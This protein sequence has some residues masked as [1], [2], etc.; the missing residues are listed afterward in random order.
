ME[1]QNK[2]AVLKINPPPKNCKE[3]IL[4]IMTTEISRN[5]EFG[6][7]D[8]FSCAGHKGRGTL[9]PEFD[10]L[11]NYNDYSIGTAPNCPL[12]IFRME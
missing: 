7:P 3:C 9:N 2:Y 6:L 4:H 1:K 12:E 8:V 5:P 11:N 10:F